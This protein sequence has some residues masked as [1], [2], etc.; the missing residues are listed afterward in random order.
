MML[1]GGLG[2]WRPMS[3]RGK[4]AGYSWDV[5]RLQ[6]LVTLSGYMAMVQFLKLSYGV[7]VRCVLYGSGSESAND[8]TSTHAPHPILN[9]GYIYNITPTHAV[10]N[11]YFI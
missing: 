6:R 3:D 8:I 7:V 9:A 1:Y 2:G 5:V 11:E 10:L 4:P